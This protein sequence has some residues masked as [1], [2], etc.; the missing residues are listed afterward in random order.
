MKKILII[1]LILSNLAFAYGDWI[2]M[3]KTGSQEINFSYS[4]CF[5][6]QAYGD[7]FSIS[8]VIK[9]GVFSC[10]YSIKY[11]PLTNSWR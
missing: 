3:N 9:G 1:G 11:N 2:Y 6:K 8:I 5:Y 10:P 7:D 4:R